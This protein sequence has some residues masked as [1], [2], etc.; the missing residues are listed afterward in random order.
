MIIIKKTFEVGVL[1]ST[2]EVGC[3]SGEVG[4]PTVE[5]GVYE[6]IAT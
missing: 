3:S 1:N 2:G 6:G 5:V 4:Y